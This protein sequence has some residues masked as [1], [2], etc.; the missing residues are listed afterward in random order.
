MGQKILDIDGRILNL[1]Y[2]CYGIWVFGLWLSVQ[3][4]LVENLTAQR[5]IKIVL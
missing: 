2:H 4:R 3:I 5:G 1:E